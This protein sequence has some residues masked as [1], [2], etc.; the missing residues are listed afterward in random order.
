M[1]TVSAS[2]TGNWSAV[3]TGYTAAD[4]IEA[5]GY[6]VTIDQNV[7]CAII[8][9][10]GGGSFVVDAAR[11]I[12]ANLVGAH[13]TALLSDTHTTGTV[14][15]TGN[16]SCATGVCI[17]K[18]GAGALTITGTATGGTAATCYAIYTTGAGAITVNGAVTGGSNA[19]AHAIYNNNAAATTTVVGAVL[20]GAAAASSGVVQK[21]AGAVTITGAV[22]GAAGIAVQ[23]DGASPTAITGN[24]TGGGAA[25]K[26]GVNNAAGAAVTITGNVTASAAS[27]GLYNALAGVVN[28]TGT[29]TG[30]GGAALYGVHNKATG[31][32]TITGNVVGGTVHAAAYGIY[33][34]AAG[35]VTI[36]GSA[37]GS[38]LAPAVYNAGAGTI[39]VATVTG[40]SGSAVY[41][42]VNASTGTINITGNATG[43]SAAT[44]YGA[45]NSG[46]G[47]I[48]VYGQ[49]ITGSVAT[50]LGAYN[51]GNGALT[52]F[53]VAGNTTLRKTNLGDGDEQ[54]YLDLAAS[55]Q[56]V[57]GTRAASG[58]Q[59]LIAAP[60]AGKRLCLIYLKARRTAASTAE[61]VLLFQAGTTTIDHCVL[62]E[63]TPGEVLLD[64]T[65]PLQFNILPAATALNLNLSAAN[66][67]ELV[68]KYLVLD[69][70]QS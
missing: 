64:A 51:A 66:S 56:R 3:V 27:V 5:A 34:E 63:Y 20:G 15:I 24:I 49:S 55:K 13:T 67:V 58:A 36:S 26:Y 33:A 9:N 31:T 59:P 7:T 53:T 57:I 18:S 16:L 17:T 30:G 41:G 48:A 8:T 10:S 4:T 44:A 54:Y 28:I 25:G 40:G 50:A 23:L 14:A 38:A 19:S 1:A 37:T 61:T 32:I 45:Y 69:A 62:N 43:G 35:V 42:V 6:T 60:A 47:L 52:V 68:I 70:E 21:G 39:T 2:G 22:T 11:T 12:T 29:V 65:T 46:L